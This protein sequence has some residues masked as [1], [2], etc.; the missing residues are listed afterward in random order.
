MPRPRR[1]PWRRA[2][3]APYIPSE[4]LR[5]P[6][7]GPDPAGGAG[8]DPPHPPPLSTTDG[9]PDY[10]TEPCKACSAPV[11]WAVVAARWGAPKPVAV[12]ADPVGPTAGTVLLT[13]PAPGVKP[14]ATVVNNPAGL[15]GKRWVY[16]RHLDTCPYRGHYRNKARQRR[17]H[18]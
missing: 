2:Q 6:A 15:F 14:L 5:P 1:D 11:I 9:A 3:I 7:A 17:E 12:D 16:R 8:T 13:A 18:A 4:R 10:P